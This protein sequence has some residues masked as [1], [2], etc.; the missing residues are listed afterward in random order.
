MCR[1]HLSPWKDNEENYKWY[2]RFNQGVV[3]LNL[4]QIGIVADRDMEMFWEIFD[5]R[6]ELCKNALLTRHKMLLGV[7][8]DSSPIH[9]QHGAIARLKKGEKIDSLLKN[10]YKLNEIEE[11]DLFYFLYLLDEE[12]KEPELTPIDK[13]NW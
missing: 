1:S 8:S 9:W 5:Q 6:L 12:N 11:M 13:I 10:G 2:G 3:S 4:P 7:T